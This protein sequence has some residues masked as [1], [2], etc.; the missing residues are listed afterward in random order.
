M[1]RQVGPISSVC[2]RVE[3]ALIME[4]FALLVIT[5]PRKQFNQQEYSV[6]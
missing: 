1:G 5:C 2:A 6:S 3:T 4:M